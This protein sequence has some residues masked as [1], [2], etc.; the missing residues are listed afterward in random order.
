[1][2]GT[3][4]RLC[5]IFLE[6]LMLLAVLTLLIKVAR[7]LLNGFVQLLGLVRLQLVRLLRNVGWVADVIAVAEVVIDAINE[8]SDVEG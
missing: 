5:L 8:G 4:Q 1:M 7:E 3:I 2:L 6:L